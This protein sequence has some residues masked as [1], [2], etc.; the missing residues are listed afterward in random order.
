M[1]IRYRKFTY[2]F[3]IYSYE[4]YLYL[5][6]MK[7]RYHI[8]SKC[9]DELHGFIYLIEANSE[10]TM[11]RKL[12][13]EYVYSTDDNQH[14]ISNELKKNGIYW[15]SGTVPRYVKEKV[16]VISIDKVCKRLLKQNG[17]LI[18]MAVENNNH[19]QNQILKLEDKN[20]K[21]ETALLEK[22]SAITK[23]PTATTDNSNNNGTIDNSKKV[24]N[25]NVFL[26]TECKDAITLNDFVSNL[27]VT[28][29]DLEC[30]KQLGYVESVTRLLK[31]S[32]NEYE[33][34]TRPIHCTDVKREVMHV[35]D[36]E[37]WKKETSTGES[38][39]ID[40]AFRQITHKHRRKMTDSYKHINH[41]SAGFEE[42][43]KIMYQI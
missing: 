10:N 41:E 15:E 43:A 4:K 18:N 3:E 7:C 11:Q 38:P 17:K 27:V 40:K 22:S 21:L 33:I 34:N 24:T 9:N 28:D 16:K 19:M 2:V 8:I 31:R 30:M 39:N 12:G 35:K 29:D 37:G 32:L 6:N 5:Q 1:S 20:A 14:D 25:I 13:T 23:K 36:H 26:N 42:K